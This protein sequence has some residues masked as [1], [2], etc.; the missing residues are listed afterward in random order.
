[1]LIIIMYYAFKRFDR[2]YAYCKAYT[3]GYISGLLFIYLIPVLVFD[4][5][6]FINVSGKAALFSL[7]IASIGCVS[8][9]YGFRAYNKERFKKE[10]IVSEHF[11]VQNP[12]IFS[13]I[14]FIPIVMFSIATILIILR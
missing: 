3:F 7:Y 10:G 12:K 14:A 6:L 4:I 1:M 13:I 2:R 5:G 8:G 9:W 11:L